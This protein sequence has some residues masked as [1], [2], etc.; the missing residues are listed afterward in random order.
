MADESSL[1]SVELEVL[2]DVSGKKL[3]HLQSH[4]GLDTISWAR[5]GAEVTG[6]DLTY[7]SMEA[8]P[9]VYLRFKNKDY[10]MP[11]MFS[12]KAVRKG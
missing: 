9:D 6:V 7:A 4:F 3:L 10:D 12:V 2:G 8:T 1:H 11:I 5:L